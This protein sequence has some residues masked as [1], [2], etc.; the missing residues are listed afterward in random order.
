[1][2]HHQE[3]GLSILYLTGTTVLVTKWISNEGIA[4]FLVKN[5]N[6]IHSYC[7]WLS[8]FCHICLSCSVIS[9]WCQLVEH[10]LQCYSHDGRQ[11]H[12]TSPSK[13]H[14]N[15]KDHHCQIA[16]SRAEC[17]CWTNECEFSTT[18]EIVPRR[19]KWTPNV[20]R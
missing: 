8:W 17:C 2:S 6:S 9:I 18:V 15:T 1:M 5:R 20:R 13:H 12:R 7:K 19:L 16:V 4:E 14:M 3:S 11:G 10:L